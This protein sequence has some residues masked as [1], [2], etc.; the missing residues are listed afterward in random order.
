VVTPEAAKSQSEMTPERWARVRELIC[1]ALDRQP[2]KRAA[3]LQDACGNDSE[4][5][6]QV[7]SLM[8]ASEGSGDAF[9]S[10]MIPARR[11]SA[12]TVIDHFEIVSLLGAGGMG[13]VYRARDQQL[14]RDVAIKLLPPNLCLNRERQRR[15]EQEARA[16]AALSHPN[17]LAIYQLG[18]YEAQPYIVAELLEGET[19]RE[20][21]KHG[22]LPTAKVIE[23][24]LQI[25]QGLAPAHEKGIVHRDLKPENIF[26]T[27]TGQLKILDFGLAKLRTGADDETRTSPDTDAGVVLG[28]LAYMSP[29]QVRGQAVDQRSDMF[30]LG[31]ILYEVL[32][33]RRAFEG[34]TGAD[35]AAAILHEEPK[36]LRELAP[37][38]PWELERVISRCL[39]KDPERRLRSMADL[40]VALQ[41]LKEESDSGRLAT[42]PFPQ[43]ESRSKIAIVSIAIGLTAAIMLTVG[44]WLRTHRPQ[45]TVF[46][47][48]PI[49]T[50]P[51]M[52]KDP[53]LSPDGTQVAFSWN[54]PTQQKFHIYVKAIGP[55]PPLQLTN[56]A[57]NDAAPMWS[58]DAG[59]I[60]FLRD[61]GAGHYKVVLIPALGGPERNLADILIFATWLSGP[62]LSWMPDSRS[63]VLAHQTRS[64]APAALFML[65]VQSG[66]KRQITFP[67]AGIL[68]D[69]CAAVSPDGQTLAFC[70]CAQV[71]DWLT[72]L[73]TV[74]LGSAAMS[75]HETKQLASDR[76][77]IGGLTWNNQGTRLVFSS[78]REDGE[79]ALWTIPVP[80]HLRS[81]ATVLE[82]GS[83][84]WPVVARRSS[85][86]AFVRMLPG[87]LNIWRS[88]LRNRGMAVEKPAPLIAS[89]RTD[90]A[91]R[92]SPDGQRIAF[93]S[94]RGGS[95][96]IWTCDSQGENCLQLTSM[97][98]E[99]TGTPS[100]SPDGNKIA[101]YSRVSGKSQ[102]FVIGADGI[103]LRQLTPGD[104]NYFFPRWSRDGEW[105]YCSSNRTGTVQ[106]WKFPSRGGSP[107]QVTRNGGFA[108]LESQDGKSI[109]YTK[110][111]AS[112]T[113]LWKLS[114][115]AHEEVQVLP[116]IL[117]HN[118]DVVD[119][120][121]Y[122]EDGGSKLQFFDT[123]VGKITT[124][125]QL[126]EGYVGLSVSPNRKSIVLT[127][128]TPG[129]SEL[130]LVD[131]FQ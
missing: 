38:V 44:I 61:L 124:L 36:P 89:T 71:G 70:R 119:D 6:S 105:I 40:A 15:F 17:I 77:R 94:S 16:A 1:E 51:G 34:K 85:R 3:Y 104:S 102:I 45:Q 58:P 9:P 95:L 20:A 2:A 97:N 32:T 92:Y 18:W 112:D 113:S 93:E 87:S 57:A 7:E 126:P 65:D 31:A 14:K 99:Y 21:L 56:T 54:G 130:M 37:S 12:G 39:R 10:S 22:T 74:P 59:A 90:F 86:L 35:L 75:G 28:T 91:P 69:G 88:E 131:N 25:A 129:S 96:Q 110:M 63:L 41:E 101:F 128:S 23:Y 27:K 26:I 46:N 81:P 114:F 118:F 4:L 76:F 53:S 13:E 11:L 106:I 83:G 62:Y 5:R 108:S 109:Y 120:G 64:D 82:V 24:G 33:S 73:Y 117:L 84:T 103:G 115:D 68:G 98:A 47:V 122:F 60:A 79:L 72:D 125:T 66:E 55:G 100:W 43:R 116:S 121:I 8:A 52:E 42:A 111:Q 80:N 50:Y 127:H 49:T 123:H 19:L 107:V 67:P 48:V 29:E 78:N 30:S